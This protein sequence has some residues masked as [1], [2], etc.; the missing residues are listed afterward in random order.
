MFKADAKRPIFRPMAT[1]L[2]PRE[3]LRIPAPVSSSDFDSQVLVSRHAVPDDD[4]RLVTE[5]AVTAY[6]R[7]ARI[8]IRRMPAGY[9]TTI[10]T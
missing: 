10:V 6:D 2:S 1:K 4:P 7:G 3:R 5:Q 9:R 8:A